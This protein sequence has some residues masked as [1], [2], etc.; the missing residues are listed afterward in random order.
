MNVAWT[1]GALELSAHPE[2]ISPPSPQ[3]ITAL[4]LDVNGNPPPEGQEV[5]FSFG[6]SQV[7]IPTR[8]G[9][10]AVFRGDEIPW[11]VEKI[12]AE[13]H[14]SRAEIRLPSDRSPEPYTAGFVL[15]SAGR[16]VTGAVVKG[17]TGSRSATT[18]GTG[19][20]LVPGRPVGLIEVSKPGYK[21]GRSELDPGEFPV[22]ELERPYP[23]LPESLAIAVDPVGGDQEPGWTWPAGTAAADINLAVARRVAS[24]LRAV[25]VIP[26]LTR[27]SDLSVSD[28][29]RVMRCESGGSSALVSIQHTAGE[30]EGVWIGHYPGS[31]GGT[32]LAGLLS[33]EVKAGTRYSAAVGETAEYLIQQTSCPAVKVIFTATGQLEDE[34]VLLEASGIWDRAYA[35]FCAILKYMGIDQ[36]GSFSLRG[37][38]TCGGEPCPAALAVVDGFLEVVPDDSGSFNL[39]LLPKGKHYVQAFSDRAE[40]E[41]IEFDEASADLRIDL[42]REP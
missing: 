5:L 30:Q 16:R 11:S 8:Q 7:S 37:L 28:V 15:D 41:R 33:D 29:D 38:V 10:A 12:A 22:I 14:G 36:A 40:S 1:G 25:G 35:I 39:R 31:K 26:H 20:F 9:R 2:S 32:R 42:D 23:G 6:K 13:F 19:Y 27:E 4:V 18:D 34:I 17:V 3:K 21:T 24:L